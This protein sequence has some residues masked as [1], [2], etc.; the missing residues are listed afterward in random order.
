M[1]GIR[2]RHTALGRVL[3]PGSSAHSSPSKLTDSL[4]RRSLLSLPI[5]KK[6]ILKCVV[7][8]DFSCNGG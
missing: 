5:T 1:Y 3:P 4:R 2:A 6:A 7:A 8:Q